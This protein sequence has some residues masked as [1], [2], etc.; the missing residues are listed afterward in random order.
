MSLK[1]FLA[2]R[3]PHEAD[4]HAAD[5]IWLE[6]Y[7][8]WNMLID[9]VSTIIANDNLYLLLGLGIQQI[10]DLCLGNFNECS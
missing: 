5:E 8:G 9:L 7:Q 1:L 10:L 3:Y 4:D 2:L 6:V